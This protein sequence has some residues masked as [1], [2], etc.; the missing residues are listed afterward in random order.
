M[1][2]AVASCYRNVVLLVLWASVLSFTALPA[3]AAGGGPF[4]ELPAGHWCYQ[5][6][7]RLFALGII[8]DDP[9]G[10]GP[11]ERRFSRYELAAWVLEALTGIDNEV[12]K[13]MPLAGAPGPRQWDLEALLNKYAEAMATSRFTRDDVRLLYDLVNLVRP[14]LEML[15]QGFN[16]PRGSLLTTMLEGKSKTMSIEGQEMAAGE[17]MTVYAIPVAIRN[18]GNAGF[19]PGNDI[20]GQSRAGFSLAMNVG[21][22]KLTAGQSY[23]VLPGAGN[24]T[25]TVVGLRYPFSQESS[26][27]AKV[28]TVYSENGGTGKLTASAGFGYQLAPAS[29]ASAAITISGETG[30][31]SKT[32]DFGLRYTVNGASISV[33]YRVSSTEGQAGENLGE[34]L[35]N[36]AAAEFSIRF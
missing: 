8:K 1:C 21:E 35:N 29:K 22:V 26:I 32:A 17:S 11:V 15:G 16:T 19:L 36:V 18:T 9:T 33:G 5:A 12:N 20:D 25:V 14:E 23:Q 27:T 2:G 31:S 13:R 30:S 24:G 6:V 7:E 34:H 4:E 28:E 10:Y 3:A